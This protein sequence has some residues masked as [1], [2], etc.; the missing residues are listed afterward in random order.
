[1]KNL[2]TSRLL[3]IIVGLIS[4]VI[5]MNGADVKVEERTLEQLE[6]RLSDIGSRL[7]EVAQLSLRSG[8]GSIGYRSKTNPS[9][10]HNEWVEIQLKEARTIEEVVLVPALSRNAQSNFHADA[11]PQALRIWAGTDEDRRGQLVGTFRA[12]PGTLP[13]IAPLV[14]KVKPVDASW[15]QIE[16]T[17][18]SRRDFDGKFCLQLSE[19]M[20]F[21]M[22][23]NVAL[24]QP[25]LTSS[26]ARD[27]YG[28]WSKEFLTD[29]HTPFL[30]DAAQGEQS[31]AYLG[32][33]IEPPVLM[34]DLEG[35]YPLSY[36]HFHIMETSDTV[37]TAL[38][39]DYGMPDHIIIEGA[40]RSDFSDAVLLLDA[41]RRNLNERG[42]IMMWA[43]PEAICRYVRI[44]CIPPAPEN[45]GGVSASNSGAQGGGPSTSAL[46]NAQDLSWIGFAEVELVSMGKNVAI[47][48]PFTGQNIISGRDMK[49]LTD[50]RNF[51][52]NVLTIHK[53]MSQLAERHDL[54]FERTLV[55][56]E[57]SLRYAKQKQTLKWL[58]WLAGTLTVVT[59]IIIYVERMLHRRELADVKQRFAADLHDEIGA[60]LH[61]INLTSQ[62]ISKRSDQLPPEINQLTGRIQS[63]AERTNRA[64]RHVTNIQTSSEIYTYLPDELKRAAERIL[65]GLNHEIEV[66]G[67]EHLRQL[68]PRRH[69]DLVLLYQ[70]CLINICRHACATRVG[71]CLIASHKNIQLIVEDDGNG[72]PNETQNEPPPS[73][74]RRAK[75]LRAKI[76]VDRPDGGGTTVTVKLRRRSRLRRAFFRK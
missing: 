9:S 1:M 25:I 19:V 47:N 11:F 59:F 52:G 50:G 43:L 24:H 26:D 38:A 51:Y 65:I 56:A 17:Q 73:L 55:S 37:P 40:T 2:P 75:L 45:S 49:V 13:R 63:V 39:G 71:T 32:K 27:N 29:G 31:N 6:Q 12:E 62:L 35:S 57:L 68:S 60:N 54:E 41:K 46:I 67:E 70:E 34:I 14:I 7:K 21:S 76:R 72:L 61:T 58:I 28:A 16:A 66:H 48:K 64:I 3:L 42:P 44:V 15:I 74:Q 5:E 20:V 23:Q 33:H 18:M 10:D 53:W 30:M 69:N 22:G 36:V 8:S 4:S